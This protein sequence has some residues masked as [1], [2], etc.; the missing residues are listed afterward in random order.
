MLLAGLFV[1]A[2][3]RGACA[4]LSPASPRPTSARPPA[5]AVSVPVALVS[6]PLGRSAVLRSSVQPG[7]LSPDS[8]RAHRRTLPRAPAR[9]GRDRDPVRLRGSRAVDGGVA[10]GVL[11][12]RPLRELPGRTHPSGRSAR[13][14]AARGGGGGLAARRPEATRR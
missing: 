13:R 10:E 8:G 4:V 2:L 11:L 12:D 14:R 5:V 9:G 6:V 1:L 7:A 3:E